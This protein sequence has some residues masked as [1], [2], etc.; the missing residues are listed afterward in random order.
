MIKVLLDNNSEAWEFISSQNVR[1]SVDNVE[2]HIKKKGI[3]FPKS[4]D[5]PLPTSHKLELDFTLNLVL[6]IQFI[7]NHS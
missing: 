3:S 1:A 7:S 6:K 4:C 5:A 2:K